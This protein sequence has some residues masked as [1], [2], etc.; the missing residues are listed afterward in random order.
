MT[1]M[2]RRPLPGVLLGA[3]LTAASLLAGGRSRAAESAPN[4]SSRQLVW[5]V[6]GL[7]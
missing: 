7:T 1:V 3:F 2:F 5:Q 6:R 4:D